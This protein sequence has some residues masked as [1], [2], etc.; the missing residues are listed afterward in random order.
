MPKF[1]LSRPAD[2]LQHLFSHVEREGDCFVWTRRR[3]PDGYGKQ[4]VGSKQWTTH[5]LVYFLIHGEIPHGY[6]ICHTCDNPPCI[7]PMHLFAATHDDNIKD[8]SRKGRMHV[9]VARWTNKLTEEQAIEIYHALNPTD[10]KKLPY[11]FIKNLAE[12]YGVARETI[13]AIRYGRSWKYLNLKGHK[14]VSE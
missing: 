4:V 12:S 1:E 8:S 10:G 2:L 3:K 7:N 5:R 11:G 14:E 6:D 9:G 13:D